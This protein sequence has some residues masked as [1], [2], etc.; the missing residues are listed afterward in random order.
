[1]GATSLA[2]RS[3]L[4]QKRSELLA[5]VSK[6]FERAGSVR[7]QNIIRYIPELIR[8]ALNPVDPTKYS[9]SLVL[10][11]VEWIL[12]WWRKRPVAMFLDVSS[13]VAKMHDYKD[14][15]AKVFGPAMGKVAA[16]SDIFS[17]E[18]KLEILKASAT[19]TA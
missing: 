13:H 5:Q 10:Q 15:V 11:P 2:Q 8:P 7:F 12:N 18:F 17:E 4:Q 9:A 1:L 3:A 16:R 14:L 6:G 19:A